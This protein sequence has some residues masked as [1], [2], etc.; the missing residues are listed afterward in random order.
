MLADEMGLGK[1]IQAIAL[2]KELMCTYKVT[3]P[4][5]ISVP[6]STIENWRREFKLWCP[7]ARLITYL[8][9]VSSRKI[10]RDLDWHANLKSMS[11]EVAVPNFNVLLTSY[12]FLRTD[13][14]QFVKTEWQCFIIDEG[15]KMKNNNSSFFRKCAAVH[16][17][18]KVLLSGTPLQNNIEELYNLIEFLDP[19]KFG[20]AFKTK[21]HE[22]RTVNILSKDDP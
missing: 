20:A 12:E 14:N 21:M 11:G 6:L 2:L 19:V 4:F 10:I 7:E 18:F 16:A 5:L 15:Q 22:L 13:F 8:G 1:T 17:Q 9:R 3:R